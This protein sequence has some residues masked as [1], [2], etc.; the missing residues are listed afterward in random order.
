MYLTVLLVQH[1]DSGSSTEHAGTTRSGRKEF[2]TIPDFIRAGDVLV[3]T[4]RGYVVGSLG[5]PDCERV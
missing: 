2:A 4:R 1:G 3:V 5:K